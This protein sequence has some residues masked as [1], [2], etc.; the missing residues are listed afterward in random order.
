MSLDIVSVVLVCEETGFPMK[1]RKNR[2][3]DLIEAFMVLKII[4]MAH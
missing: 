2:I 1:I 4:L 3:K